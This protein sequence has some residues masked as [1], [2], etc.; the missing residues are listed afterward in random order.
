MTTEPG[1]AEPGWPATSRGWYA[2]FVLTLA[3]VLSFVDRQI[4]TLLVGPIQADLDLNDTQMSLLIGAA[5]AICYT[6]FGLPLG[7]LVDRV[8]RRKV[9]AI[10]ITFWSV[11]TAACGGAGSYAQLFLARMGVGLGEATLTPAT[12]SLLSDSFPPS[13]LVRAIGVFMSGAI[14]GI[15]FAY[16]LGGQLAAWI[17]ANEQVT[18]PMVGTVRGWQA[19]F[20]ILLLPGLLIALLVSFIHEPPRRKPP[21]SATATPPL[22]P[23][24]RARARPY[25][26]LFL[27]MGA[28]S[29]VVYANLSWMPTLMT[30][31]FGWDPASIG[32]ALGLIFLGA[33]L[34]GNF[35][36]AWV[37]GRLLEQ[38]RTA[39][40]LGLCILAAA[41]LLLVGPAGPVMGSATGVLALLVPTILLTS[42]PTAI[43]PAAIQ[44]TTPGV[45]RGRVAALYLFATQMLGLLLGPTTVALFTDY[46]FADRAAIG[47]SQSAAVTAATLVSLAAFL[48]ARRPFVQLARE[49][50]AG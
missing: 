45:Y 34:A 2:T 44:M 5:F 41:L 50:A 20:F 40:Y 31:R 3:Y 26:L 19:P 12:Y 49:T 17:G 30:R 16:L 18:L 27:A 33:G 37:G 29:V 7:W 48:A 1:T 15:G 22:L 9:A 43:V 21:I 46:V 25:G 28:Q 14:I 32:Q 8:S 42:I 39:A 24:L 36:G 4:L 11:M 38:K 10:G 47:L 13:R 23:F 6:S 35:L